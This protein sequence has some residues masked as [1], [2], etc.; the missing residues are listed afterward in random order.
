V[1]DPVVHHSVFSR[2][3][4]VGERLIDDWVGEARRAQNRRAA[5]RTLIL[6]AGTGLDVPLIGPDATEV[7]LLEPDPTMRAILRRRFPDHPVVAAPAERT[8]LDAASFDTVLSSL[9][10]CSVTDVDAV[11]A[12]VARV[13]KPGG[14]FLFLEHVAHADPGPRRLQ[15]VL[16][17][18]WRMVGGGCHLTRDVVGAIRRSPLRLESVKT[19]RTGLLLP[20]VRGSAVRPPVAE[21]R[22]AAA[23]TTD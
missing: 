23:V 1:A 12:E 11:L 13:L 14:R 22:H 21:D 9:V 8:G 18:V 3:Y 17:P 20:V 7:W 5:G 16:T 15:A 6:G 4:H 19:V 2:L 10:L